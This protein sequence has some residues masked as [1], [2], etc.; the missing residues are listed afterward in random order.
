[1]AANWGDGTPNVSNQGKFG[2][3]PR[4][5]AKPG[6]L[7]GKFSAGK[8]SKEQLYDHLSKLGIPHDS[9]EDLLAKVHSHIGEHLS[10]PAGQQAEP[11]K[12]VRKNMQGWQNQHNKAMAA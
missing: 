6:P 4:P 11:V 8:I 7:H 3:K 1:M 5:I 9:P 12:K 2:G 10:A